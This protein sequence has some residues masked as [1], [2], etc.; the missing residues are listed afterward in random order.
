MGVGG[1]AQDHDGSR[2]YTTK[3][4]G[5]RSCHRSEGLPSGQGSARDV[6]EGPPRLSSKPAPLPVLSC[7]IPLRP[8]PRAH[9]PLCAS[10][11]YTGEISRHRPGVVTVGSRLAERTSAARWNAPCRPIRKETLPPRYPR[12]DLRWQS[13]VEGLIPGALR[14]IWS[15][16]AMLRAEAAAARAGG[17]PGAAAAA[18]RAGGRQGAAAVTARAGGRQGA[19]AAAARA[20]GRQGMPRVLTL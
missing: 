16:F 14:Q 8:V 20:G 18:A 11:G 19:A 3:E 2:E 1:R 17:R 13:T 5:P 9:H 7:L 12:K 15:H 10:T 4:G 6:A